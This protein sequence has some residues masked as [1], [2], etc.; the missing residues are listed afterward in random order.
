LPLPRLISF[1][2]ITKLFDKASWF[3]IVDTLFS[4]ARR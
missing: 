4:I 2:K 1:F 3:S